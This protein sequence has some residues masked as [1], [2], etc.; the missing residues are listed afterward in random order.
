MEGSNDRLQ[1]KKKPNQP[2]MC[3]DIPSI[4]WKMEMLGSFTSFKVKIRLL[5]FKNPWFWYQMNF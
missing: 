1:F 5:N 4:P 3:P 2:K